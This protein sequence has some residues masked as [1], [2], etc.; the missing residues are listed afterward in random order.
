MHCDWRDGDCVG[1]D[2]VC[3]TGDAV[4]GGGDVKVSVVSTVSAVSEVG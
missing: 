4:G 1:G 3:A 2:L